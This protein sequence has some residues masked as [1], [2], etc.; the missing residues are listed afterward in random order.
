MAER[1]RTACLALFTLLLASGS[2]AEEMPL[3]WYQ[4]EIVLFE[5]LSDAA[6]TAETLEHA[7]TGTLGPRSIALGP[8]WPE[9]LRPT[10]TA[11]LEMLWAGVDAAP[12]LQ[13]ISPGLDPE[14]EVAILW[15]RRLNARSGGVDL[16]WLDD[17]E[18]IEWAP[19]RVLPVPIPAIEPTVRFERMSEALDPAEPASIEADDFEEAEVEIEIPLRLA[20]RSIE[21]EALQLAEDA[22]RLRRAGDFR[23]LA[24]LGW[25]QP[26]EAQAPAI[27]VA[28]QWRD[29]ARDGVR[30]T[31]QIGIALRRYLHLE[32]DLMWLDGAD[33]ASAA[34][35][36]VTQA[37]RMRS[38]ET[39]YID[40][41]RVGAL[42]RVTPF[43]LEAP[44]LAD[45][46][47]SATPAP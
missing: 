37:R 8:V 4:V 35:V 28:V 34:W 9:P 12:R 11:E 16:D 46:P 24:H 1:M 40:H 20:F 17:V 18:R 41:P 21:S 13:R 25:R 7:P 26:F 3:R 38:G 47:V 36:P 19:E 23:V 29:P 27:P 32:I 43:E 44:L 45:A 30:L 15:L 22:A 14:T 2:S 5:I 33:E 39:H 6:V 10:R 42:V 31:G